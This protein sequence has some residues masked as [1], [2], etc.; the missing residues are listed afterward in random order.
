MTNYTFDSH[1]LSD[2][3]S[4]DK[5]LIPFTANHT[6]YVPEYGSIIYTVWDIDERFL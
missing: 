1:D 2:L 4:S 3:F 6:K 5:P